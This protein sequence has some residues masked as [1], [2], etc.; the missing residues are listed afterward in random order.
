MIKHYNDIF[1]YIQTQ[2]AQ[3]KQPI[4]VN[5]KWSWS[6]KD[7][8]LLTEL[9]TNSQS[10]NKTDWTPIKNITRP[11]LNLQHRTEDIELKDVQ[12][13][14]D[15]PDN[16]HLSFL[17]K[18]YHDDVF[19]KENDL[20]TYFDELNVSR[21]DFGGGLSKQLNCPC[22]EVV[23]L[24]SIAFCDQ[25]DMLSA[26]IGLKH[27][28]SPDQLLDMGQYGWGN[29]NNGA[30]I[31][32][33]DLIALSKEEKKVDSQT[34]QTPGRYLEI[35]EVHGNLPK[36]FS[37]P[38]DTSEE[39]E[40]SLFICAFYQKQSSSD[41]Q[42]VILYTAKETESPFKLIKRDPVYGR[43][44][45][46]G[47]A[48]ELFEAQVWVNYDMI[49]IQ[50]MLD[51]ASK[52]ILKATGPN[53]SIIAKKQKVK[54]LDNLTIIDAGDG[55][56]N[57]V[58]TFPRNM[59][60]FDRSVAEWENHAKEIGAAA[61]PLTGKEPSSG[62]PFASLQ[63]QIRQGMGLHDYRRGQYAK[64]IEEIYR[65]WIIPHIEKKICEGATFLSELSLEELQMVAE[66]V[67]TNAVN[68]K[69][70]DLILSGQMV[71]PEQQAQMTQA[72]QQLFS[73][74]GNKH[75]IEILKGEFKNKPL[76]VKANVAG[77]SKNLSGMVDKLTNVFKTVISN[78]YILASPPIA[79]L[80]NKII[81]AS[82]LDP[83]DLS[84]LNIPPMP[85]R[86]MTEGIDY[87]DLATPPNEAQTAMLKLAG[88]DI[89]Q[90][91]QPGAVTSSVQQNAMPVKK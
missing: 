35:Y 36:K 80:F 42:G 85:A 71:T 39:Y 9:Y 88:I 3:F 6:F 4:P 59:Q 13:Y 67:T 51:A 75:F 52:T 54:D 5:E 16:Y 72:Y 7:H 63:E 60:L 74:K 77:K 8:C 66:R 83:I 58:D 86:R 73:K 38:M 81:E 11:I 91:G 64:H 19:A 61:D 28:Y 89:P 43:A 32:L 70:K 1:D 15:N 22:P 14:V 26:P 23:P 12:I 76:G 55:D 87:K 21:I 33:K 84:Q 34:V 20:D 10:L 48:E 82:G 46:F 18:K 65:D 24:Q 44:L 45:G 78:P 17:V 30:T 27:Y 40:T 68:A 56:L 49:R 69:I 53:S 62:T 79:K 57:Q 47:G 90:G 37:D 31:S 50:D 2:E 25:T 41:K 29:T